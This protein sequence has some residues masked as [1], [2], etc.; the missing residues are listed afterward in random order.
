MASEI[1]MSPDLKAYVFPKARNPFSVDFKYKRF[2]DET[3]S[4]VAKPD[5]KVFPFS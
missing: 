5:L 1:Q 2:C 3:D 4:F